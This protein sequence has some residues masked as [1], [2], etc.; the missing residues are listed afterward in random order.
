[1][2][3]SLRDATMPRGYRMARASRASR[4]PPQRRR[5]GSS[6]G[7]LK[8]CCRSRFPRVRRRRSGRHW[9]LAASHGPDTD[10]PGPCAVR[11]D[12]TVAEL[13]DKEVAA[14]LTKAG[15]RRRQPPFF[16]SRI[17]RSVN[18]SSRIGRGCC[19]RNSIE[20]RHSGGS[21]GVCRTPGQMCQKASRRDDSPAA[22]KRFG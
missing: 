12:A 14:E 16:D 21:G 8:R 11:V 20:R 2:R 22:L 10:H 15:R 4:H 5:R 19:R 17:V 7:R 1:M 3:R 9:C 13:A 18:R 6:G